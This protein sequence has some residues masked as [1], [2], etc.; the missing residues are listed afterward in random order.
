VSVEHDRKFFDN[1]MLILGILFAVTLGLIG[2]ARL[3]ASNTSIPRHAEDPLNQRQVASRLA[4]FARVAVAGKDNA[5]LTPPAPAAAAGNATVAADLPGDQVFAQVC[6]AC[7]TAGIAG[8][9]KAGDKAAWAPRIAQGIDLLH[10]HALEGFQGKAGFMPPK[11]GRA[12]LSD[13][14]IMNAVDYLVGQAK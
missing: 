4:P 3:I 13:R 7:H 8:A 2:V 12:D 1:F 9:P 14:S 11:G 5:A 10:K 6:T